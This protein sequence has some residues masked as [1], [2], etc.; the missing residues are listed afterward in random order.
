MSRSTSRLSTAL[1]GLAL[2]TSLAVGL[3]ACSSSGGSPSAGNTGSGASGG[4][5][6]V[7]FMAPN[8]T[9]TRYL[10]QDGPDFKKAMA[11]LDPN[12]TVKFDTADGTSQTQ[13]SQV[14]AAISAGASALVMV[15]ADPNTSGAILQAAQ[16]AKVPVIGYE[17]TPL[18]GPMYAQVMFDP[19]MAGKLQAQYFAS[20][21][22]SG[23]LGA[24]PVTVARLYG[25]QGDV[26]TTQMLA[27]QNAVLQ[28][29]IDNGSIKV[30]CS[31]YVTNWDPAVA[32]SQAQQ[33]LT[34][35]QNKVDAFL[36][37]YDGIA[38]GIIAAETSANVKIPV[39]GGQNP[40]LTG[41]QYMLTGQLQ[42]DVLKPFSDEATAAAKLAV[43]AMSGK[44][45]GALAT[46][47]IDNGG[48]FKIPTAYLGETYIHLTKGQDPG[49]VVQKIVDLGFFTWAQICTG[50]AKD[51]AT[52][53]QKN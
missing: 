19:N 41:P 1:K 53:K 42:D 50:P 23:A 6:T 52:C 34:K 37:F 26:Y 48:G 27:G 3:T 21:V 44:Q 28:P 14:N 49:V 35:T 9:P 17:N 33:C 51:T 31:S 47:T 16:A 39:Y 24:K 22:Q 7:Y 36:G 40:E 38:A 45:P 15:A 5:K 30:V 12:V 2:I 10:Q 11:T 43:A 20:Q 8:T 4:K 25:N 18:N 13:L 32:Q 29:L 46:K